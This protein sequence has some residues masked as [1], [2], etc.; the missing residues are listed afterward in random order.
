MALQQLPTPT[1]DI[2][3]AR[4]D[5]AEHGYVLI[6]DALNPR[7][8]EAMRDRLVEQA[9]A[10]GPLRG[11]QRSL[12]DKQLRY[13]VGGLL[14]KGKIFLELLDPTS[15]LHQLV[16]DTL[17]PSLE[18]IS[19]ALWN[20][21]QGFLLSSVDGVVKRLE[22]ATS[23]DK[24]RQAHLNPVFHV[25]AAMVPGWLDYP[26]AVNSFYFLTEYTRDNGGTLVVPGSHLR[27][28]LPDR[29]TYSNDGAI[30]IEAPAGTA[31][32][33]DGRLWHAA[34]INVNGELRI[35]IDCYYSAPWI[36]QRWL[37]PMNLRQ[38]V[39]DLMTDAQL[40]LCGFDTMYQSEYGAFGGLG[41]IEPTLG[42]N[43]VTV[44]QQG[45]GELHLS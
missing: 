5:M 30:A 4:R 29:T 43:N 14:N 23:G 40:R 25:D 2:D 38:D 8:V 35:H 42:R 36:R 16:G 12:D 13:D 7:Q 9:L 33:V 20:L 31:L 10:E 19:A 6:A 44:Q 32:V 22:V 26:V 18:P 21:E 41:I 27:R 37:M 24:T 15:L 45:I 11:E 34:G 1:R 17:R 3:Q 28:A 39:V